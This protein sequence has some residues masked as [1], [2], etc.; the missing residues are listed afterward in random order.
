MKKNRETLLPV[1][2]PEMLKEVIGRERIWFRLGVVSAK[3]EE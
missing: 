3:W 1:G 2:L